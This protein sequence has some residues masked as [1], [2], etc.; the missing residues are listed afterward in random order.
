MAYK[1][2]IIDD[3]EFLLDMY[4]L[5][6]KE[7]GFSVETGKSSIEAISKAEEFAPDI[8]LVDIVMP[9]VDGFEVI[10][11]LKEKIG[12]Q[13]KIIAFSNLDQKES[14][15]KAFSMGADD[16]IKKSDYTPSE[17]FKK[18]KKILNK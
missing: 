17:V 1:I 12:S 2:L 10:K 7:G 18:V 13:A 4:C 9:N 8:V 16:F 5:K 14:I 3:D 11:S 15:D 6:F